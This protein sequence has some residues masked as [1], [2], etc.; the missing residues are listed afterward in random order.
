VNCDD[1]TIT[2]ITDTALV[3][4][5]AAEIVDCT[6]RSFSN[7]GSIPR[8]CQGNESAL[9]GEPPDYAPDPVLICNDNPL[10]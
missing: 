4:P 8:P 3:N 6:H 10:P 5:A 7:A 9:A 2:D 1:A